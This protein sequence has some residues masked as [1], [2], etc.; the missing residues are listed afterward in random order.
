M[1]ILEISL[2]GAAAET[3]FHLS[4]SYER[5]LTTVV[6]TCTFIFNAKEPEDWCF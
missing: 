3:L 2:G 5:G 1:E 4:K 6:K